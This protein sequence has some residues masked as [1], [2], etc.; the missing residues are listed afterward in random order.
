MKTR[1]KRRFWAKILAFMLI[2]SMMVGSMTTSSFAAAIDT[3]VTDVE[4]DVDEAVVPETEESEV[5]SESESEPK[6]AE[7]T[8][9]TPDIDLEP[10]E[11]E[12]TENTPDADS[13]PEK[14]EE[15]ENITGGASDDGENAS[16]NESQ[17]DSTITEITETE[18][19][20][21]AEEAARPRKAMAKTRSTSSGTITINVRV[22]DTSTWTT[23]DVGTDTVSIG[24]PELI[25]S[26][27]YQIPQLS[28]FVDSNKFGNV[29]KV[30][31]NWYFPSHDTQ[32]GANVEWST[33]AGTKTMTYW[34]TW[35]KPGSGS[36]DKPGSEENSETVGGGS[37][38]PWTK[39]IIYH[40]NYPNGTDYEYS[41]TYTIKPYISSGDANGNLKTFAATGFSIPDGYKLKSPVWNTEKDGNGTGY[42]SGQN[43][44]FKKSDKRDLHLY[45][46]YEP[47]G[48]IVVQQV[49]LTYKDGNDVIGERTYSKGDEVTVIDQSNKDDYTFKGWSETNGGMVKYK[50][51]ETF[52][53]SEDKILYAVWEKLPD[54]PVDNGEGIT[55]TKTR[56]SINGDTNA[57]TAKLG[58][59][60]VWKIT[61]VNNSNVEK[62][63]TLTEL[64]VGAT[65]SEDV[66]TLAP[67]DPKTVTATYIVTDEDIAK[68]EKL[69]NI[70]KAS[71]GEQGDKENT[72]A[73]DDGT[74]VVVTVTWMDGYTDTPIKTE[75]IV[76]GTD[77]T[78][79]YPEEEPKRDGYRFTKW[80]DPVEDADGNITITAEWEA[81]STTLN[82]TK[83]ANKTE[84][85]PGDTVVY[86][87][88][89]ENTGTVAAAK[90]VKVTDIL[91]G[92]LKFVSA[93]LNGTT[94]TGNGNG[95]EIGDI[96]AGGAITLTITVTVKDTTIAGTEISNTAT[97]S[98][99]NNPKDTD[100]SG[101]VK[102]TVTD[103][104]DD[105]TVTITLSYVYVDGDGNETE[106]QTEVKVPVK[107]GEDYDVSDRVPDTLTKDGQSYKKD[108]VDGDLTGKAEEDK[109]VKV[110]Y[111]L[112]ETEEPDPT[113][114]P[115]PTPTPGPTPPTPGPTPTP[116]PTPTPGPA[117]T[118]TPA[119]VVPIAPTV[120][121]A[122]TPAATQ[123][124]VEPEANIEDVQTSLAEEKVPLE[125]EEV[126]LDE[127]E[128]PLA[129]GN[130]RKWALINFALMN[131]AIFESIMLLIGYFV[132]T[133]NDK[134][135]EEEEEKRKLKKKGIV[136]ILSTPV[137]VI[138]LIAFILTE[139]I[140]LPTGFV[141]KYTIL[142]AIIAIV[143]TVMVVLSNKKY[144]KE[145]EEA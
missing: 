38:T 133:K 34:V 113:P 90:D 128:V 86:T 125:N 22:Y 59:T 130:G 43:Y 45:A 137:A 89:V 71:T 99:T 4:E 52:L 144:Q 69:Y 27:A 50:A 54:K 94:I 16:D 32:P 87:I 44:Y 121:P 77:Y 127:E 98:Y 78:D 39:K 92:N 63:V 30:V 112:E 1:K 14:V 9:S 122:V 145:E 6:E 36:G 60:I 5:Q 11:I 140:T 15:T 18:T 25:Q 84:V 74:E 109:T 123:P 40:S 3:E 119:A 116:T 2:A 93:E 62:T 53:I 104:P 96:P 117:P 97:A 66:F 120:I 19:D 124:E 95:Y 135:E 83:T 65:L 75:Q 101:E 31:G 103:T 24:N 100:P 20:T 12:E 143:Q 68:G 26:A 108:S 76:K 47:D 46:Q 13:E 70:V 23:Y 7:E 129:A 91:D 79:L 29:T 105:E 88:T 55:V 136:R 37:K 106:L 114:T 126:V 111:V 57:T 21:E 48:A 141:D 51:G 42:A 73:K 82:V 58:D 10:E 67:G 81:L 64:L 28:H 80:G 72:E 8:E 102:V 33:N 35:Y 49:T 142:M 131:L 118:P 115:T 110:T 134:D 107:K 138:S 139:D 132:K 56:Y 85:N 41:V 61:V 17:D